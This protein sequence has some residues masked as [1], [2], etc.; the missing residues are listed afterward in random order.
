MMRQYQELKARYE[1]CLLFFRLGD[2]YE[3]FFEDA[4]RASRLLGLTLTARDGGSQSKTPMCGVPHHSAQSYIGKLLKLGEKVAV[5]EQMEDPKSVKGLVR[6]DVVRV[7]TPGTIVESELLDEKRNN[8]LVAVA[9]TPEAWGLALADL[10]T[11]EFRG[12]GQAGPGAPA[13]LRAELARL[14]P[15]EVLASGDLREWLGD[16]GCTVTPLDRVPPRETGRAL[17]DHFGA[18]SLAPYGLEDRPE[19]QAAAAGVLEYARRTQRG[20]TDHLRT[21]ARYD[22]DGALRLDPFTLDALEVVDSPRGDGPTLLSV[23]DRTVSAMGSRTL[24]GWLLRPLANA[25]DILSRLDAVQWLAESEGPRGGLRTRLESCADLERIGARIGSRSATPRDLGALRASLD[26]VATVRRDLGAAGAPGLI[27]EHAAELDPLPA[28]REHLGRALTDEPPPLTADGGVI[29]DGFHP[30]VD[31]LRRLAKSSRD[32]LLEIQERERARTGIDGLRISYNSVFGYTFE[33]GR[34]KAKQAPPEW[35]RRQTLSNVERFS[36][37]ELKELERKILGAEDR[38]LRLEAEL[39]AGVRDRCAADLAALLVTARALG[40]L[41][42]LASLAEVAVRHGYI[43]PAID[44]A[45]TIEIVEGRHPALER[46]LPSF[47][48]NDVRLVP[49]QEQIMLITGPNMAGK[50]TFLRQTAIL[51]L[52]AHAG[53]FVPAKEAR[54]GVLDGIYCRIGASDRLA[55]GLSTFMVEMVEVAQILNHATERSLLIFDE[56]GRGTSTWD[57]TAIAWAIV[58]HLARHVGAKTL[59]AT[60]YFELTALTETLPSV[61]NLNVLVREWKGELVFLYKIVPGR[62]ERS[63]GVQVAKLAGLPG[64]LIARARERLAELE[65]QTAAP[66]PAE[67]GAQL[68]LFG[69]LPDPLRRKLEEADP[70]RLTPMEAL[71]LVG[72]LKDLLHGSGGPFSNA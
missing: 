66:A 35:E 2:F 30:E 64:T 67:P 25:G 19:L 43:R 28:L 12:T 26:V 41:D 60:H 32:V 3:M 50:S 63:Y 56:V 6:R 46:A 57:G 14:R 40:R 42:A 7:L 31:D 5:C 55:K 9:G 39:F 69:P 72:E 58:E 22:A 17:L 37:P 48:S 33:I 24:R 27:A 53:S 36:T 8:W 61:R 29:R 16:P 1:D 51:A 4:E 18:V 45:G 71:Q 11:G 49:W 34:S 68:T 20:G 65:S 54:I 23:L 44:P 13:E 15:A 47:V 62:A 38:L 21:F 52:M 10:S 70:D 59:F